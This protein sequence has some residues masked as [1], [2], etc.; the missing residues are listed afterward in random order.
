MTPFVHAELQ[1]VGYIVK[2]TEQLS[3]NDEVLAH[4][5][6]YLCVIVCGLV[7]RAIAAS[8]AEYAKQTSSPQVASYADSCLSYSAN[9]NEERLKQLL[10][11]FS[12]QW[13]DDFENNC[14]EA[15]KV[16]LDSLVATRNNIAHGRSVGI[17]IIRVRD[18]FAR[19]TEVIRHVDLLCNTK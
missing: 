14:S 5:A 4:W 12:A 8:L 11:R 17:T 1:R 6:R 2:L 3:H 15:Q 7:E 18:Y 16:A 19:V 9:L 13:R 10:G